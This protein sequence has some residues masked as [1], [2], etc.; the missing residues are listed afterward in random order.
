MSFIY[1][2]KPL[3]QV[4]AAEETQVDTQEGS[5]VLL[6]CRFQPVHKSATCFWLTHTNNDHD[7]A[8]ID[9]KP[10]SPNYRVNM[11]L[12]QGIYDLEILNVSYERNNGKYECRVKVDGSGVNLY[13]KNV[14]LTVLR[15]PGPPSISTTSTPATEGKSL[16]LH[17]NT[18][19]GSPEPEVKWYRGNSHQLLYS[20]R[21]LTIEPT[22]EDDG[23]VY[24]CVV[25]NRAM[26]EGKTLN[27]NVTL[28]VNYFPRVSVG[29]EN[30]L[31]VEANSPAVLRCN[32]DSKP[33]V[34]LV[35]WMKDGSFVAT[36]LEHS[37]RH[38]T[39]QDAGKYTC[40]ADNSLGRSGE[41]SLLLDV[42]YPPTVAIEGDSYRVAE[43]ED[44]VTVHCNVSANPWPS[45]IEWLREG[46]P[47]FRQSG[48]IL[49]LS[50]VAAEHAGNYTCR[51]LNTIHPSGGNRTNYTAVAG[52]N[53]RIR[54][55]PGPAKITPDSPV[56]VENSR[57]ILT[58][59]ASPAG[60][61][62]AQYKWWKEREDDSPVTFS[63]IA[64]P[65]FVINSVTLGHDGT[66]KCQALNEIGMGEEASVRL[67]VQQHPKMST[68]LK[69][70]VS[71]TVGASSFA[72]F[73]IAQGKPGPTVHW[74][75]D[76][77]L[78]DDN[79]LYK[80]ETRTSRV[81][82]NV[83]IVNSTLSFVGNGRPQNDK[84]I[85]S[86]RGKYKCVFEHDSKRA[87]SEMMLRV[88]HAPIVLHK[89]TK[90]AYN[91][92]E[93]AEVTCKVQAWPKAEF[94]WSLDSNITPLQGS[95][96]DGH[97]EISSTANDDIYTSVLKITNIRESDYGE[98]SCRAA[99]S[100]GSST[101]VITLQPK[102]APEKPTD[103]SAVEI[104]PTYVT[105]QWEIGFDGGLE[106]TK[107][108]VSY[109]RDE[110]EDETVAPDCAPPRS[111][112]GTWLESDCHRSNPCNI[113]GLEQHQRYVFRVKA[114]NT[115]NHSDYSDTKK[116]STTVAKISTPQRVSYD[117]E[118]RA[119]I[120]N[121]GPTC[122]SLVASIE[123]YEGNN[124]MNSWREVAEWPIAALGSAPTPI[125]GI[126][127]DDT[128]TNIEPRLR[129]RLC[130][131][132]EPQKC[133]DWAEAEIG[134]SYIAQAG[135]LATPTLI[136]LV[137]SGAVFLLFAALL[138][139]F[140]R[141][142]RKHAAKAKDYEMDSNAVRPSLVA[143]NGQQTQAPPPYYAENKALE[144]SLDRALAMEDSKSP[145]YAQP[146]YGY[147]QPNHN[148]NGVNMAYLD[149]SYS[150][151]NNGGSVNSQDSIWQMKS[152][153]ANGAN[154][155]YDLGGYAAT[156]SDYP[157]HPHYLPQREDYRE[158]HN[159]S[160]QQFCTEPFATV[161][162]S[163][164]HVDSPYDV[165][166][167]PYQETYDEDTKPPQ[168]VSLSYDESLESGYSTPN[169]RR[170]R[171]IREIIV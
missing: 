100:Q 61:P 48:S 53:I 133:S 95:S 82:G 98:Y 148:I 47:E 6:K 163:Q 112:I 28:S 115:K 65:K 24:R 92:R 145:A 87:E 31:K 4:Q 52:V 57:V 26:P 33:S 126:L 19:G 109:Y 73:C 166:G 7:N 72:V 165:S 159:L 134:P 86:D 91:L 137:V 71:I 1:T 55:K 70:H 3:S 107:Y 124:G 102:G 42:L 25:R 10:L 18:N 66:Y 23:A 119:L 14:T 116:F 161:V 113:T 169:G 127:D 114:Y 142:R 157:A 118:H 79:N 68:K 78:I 34:R 75:K 50:R 54:H 140:C 117:P 76:K 171:I 13:H 154:P 88:E 162:K 146:G 131:K 2:N 104:G 85:A 43:V 103:L 141:C 32:V 93:T 67:T 139:L 149:N 135:A 22:R 29:P 94:Q 164:K 16:E 11:D 36:Q 44:T 20:G 39:L 156:E 151:S 108:F 144:H 120:I 136:A 59:M 17:C 8:A 60:F 150:N 37:I 96:S 170:P 128:V 121:V 12:S 62:E 69:P 168:Q 64:G 147:H 123:K 143:G 63:E 125:E 45:V 90:V 152:A 83:I 41:A 111:P 138:L 155:P 30:P 15:A 89:H 56:A 106:I 97:Y 77:E 58:C 153:A 101:S 5:T 35:K 84:I 167:L 158:S 110:I 160:R 122:L 132:S 51:A 105:L 9:G 99:N 21:T 80:I 46:R 49:R 74:L 129:V 130:L 27:A 40:Y 81:H 38:V